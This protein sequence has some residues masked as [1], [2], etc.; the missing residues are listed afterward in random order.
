MLNALREIRPMGRLLIY[1]SRWTSA[2]ERRQAGHANR[3]SASLV[4]LSKEELKRMRTKNDNEIPAIYFSE[5]ATERTRGGQIETVGA[6][7]GWRRHP[8]RSMRRLQSG[9]S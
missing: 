3:T 9:R 1:P 7:A 5:G 6:R 4:S 8:D 2:F